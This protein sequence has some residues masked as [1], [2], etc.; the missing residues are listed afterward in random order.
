M[1]ESIE[2]EEGIF[3]KIYHEIDSVFQ[4]NDLRYCFI[5]GGSSAS[6]TF[7]YC[8]RTIVYML[9]GENNNSLVF[10]KYS[11]DIDDSIYDTFKGIV[12]DW[13]L[14]EYFVFQKHYIKCKLTNSYTKFKGLDDSEKIKGLSGIKKICL[15]ELNQFDLLDFK[16]VKK[17]LRGLEGQQVFGIFNP[18]SE[19]SFIK[20]DIFDNEIFTDAPTS[21]QQKQINKSGDTV[22]L[23]TCYLDNIWIVGPQFYD[24]H[25]IADFEK[26][27]INDINYYN[28]YALGHW[29]KLRTG[30]EF[31]KQFKSDKHVGNFPY[32]SAE[33]LHIVFDE[34]VLPYLTC[35][36]FQLHNKQL[37][38]IDEIMLIDPYNTLKDTCEEFI[39][40]YG[41]N[42]Q[43][44]FV[45]GDATSR[46]QD[47]KLQ[48]GQNFYLLI[49]NY[50]SVM[51]P[52]FR[53]P[54]ANPS[55][56]MTRGFVN[57]ILAGDVEELSLGFDTRCRNSINDYQYCTEDEDGKVNKKVIRDKVT[58]QSYQEYGHASD[59]L[60][61]IICAMYVDKYKKFIKG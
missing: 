60:R 61:Y 1:I 41:S 48:K 24:K 11:T 21:I 38:Q 14:Q 51:K 45:Y 9:E 28:I 40:R 42:Q 25:V 52:N 15:E 50:L 35:N 16:Q 30:G 4:N 13:K 8:Q 56:M 34:N 46:K 19:M 47:T 59:C 10:R 39:K 58:G 55:V 31:Y 43:G 18:V 5:Y 26:D 54:Q 53:V 12:N 20:R 23:R 22:V 33:P 2:F 27:K 57:A 49:K 3:N 17:R 32:N 37:R 36:V 44:L 29:G 7:S 6:K